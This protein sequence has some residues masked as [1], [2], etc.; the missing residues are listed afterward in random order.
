MPVDQISIVTEQLDGYKALL[1]AAPDRLGALA[2]G[3]VKRTMN[4]AKRQQQLDFLRSGNKAFR[5]ISRHVHYTDPE[6]GH[7]I[8]TSRL[9]V[10]K[11]GSGSLA[12]IAVFGTS[13]GG[14]THLHPVFYLNQ[15]MG[16]ARSAFAE[17]IGKALHS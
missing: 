7:G 13:K 2:V 8:I 12:N 17:A 15:E 9:G 5:A 1:E 3:T 10:E 16:K 4:D 14:G 11:G 6:V